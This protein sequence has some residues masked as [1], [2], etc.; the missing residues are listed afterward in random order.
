[1]ARYHHYPAIGSGAVLRERD[2]A[3]RMA[4]VILSERTKLL[5]AVEDEKGAI[6]NFRPYGWAGPGVQWTH[7]KRYP[8]RWL[9]DDSKMIAE[10][11]DPPPSGG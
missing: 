2:G 8:T 1:M 7:V 10:F 9:R 6:L 11:E 5:V 4:K 3:T